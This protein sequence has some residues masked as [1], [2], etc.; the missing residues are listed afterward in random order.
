ML[1]RSSTG[2]AVERPELGRLFGDEHG[3]DSGEREKID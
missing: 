2:T 1:C 3:R